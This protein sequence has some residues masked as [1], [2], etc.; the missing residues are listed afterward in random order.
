MLDTVGSGMKNGAGS[1]SAVIRRLSARTNCRHCR[2]P[3]HT[4]SPFYTPFLVVK[5]GLCYMSV[6]PAMVM[7]GTTVAR[8]TIITTKL[9][10]FQSNR[11]INAFQEEDDSQPLS[12][13][14]PP[15]LHS[16]FAVDFSHGLVSRLLATPRLP[17]KWIAAHGRKLPQVKIACVRQSS[18]SDWSHIVSC[19]T[20]Q[21]YYNWYQ[22]LVCVPPEV[23]TRY[24][25]EWVNWPGDIAPTATPSVSCQQ[26]V[27]MPVDRPP[28]SKMPLVVVHDRPS[29]TVEP[30]RRLWLAI[31]YQCPRAEGMSV[32][33]E[34]G[35]SSSPM[36]S[37]RRSWSPLKTP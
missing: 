22:R 13:P 30:R 25:P 3:G 26:L 33:V 6:V 12:P 35:K 2:P 20:D 29:S 9:G 5:I 17:H 16:Q 28:R 18:S 7:P 8:V 23:E 21:Q 24:A 15:P 11:N 10:A 27:T 36:N 32:T 31:K 37:S 14:K 34:H 19:R 1:D 4:K